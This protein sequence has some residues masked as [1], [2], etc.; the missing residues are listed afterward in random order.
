MSF[1]GN[2]NNNN[3]NNGGRFHNHYVVPVPA[4]STT[5]SG[6]AHAGNSRQSARDAVAEAARNEQDRRMA[7]RLNRAVLRAGTLRRAASTNVA[8]VRLR[9]T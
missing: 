1:F 8:P 9:T 7:A 3:N 6:P 4:N 2:N 5:P